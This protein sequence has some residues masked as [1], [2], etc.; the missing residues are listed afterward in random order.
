[1][2]LKSSMWHEVLTLLVSTRHLRGWSQEE[3]AHRV[4]YHS[5]TL[6]LWETGKTIPSALA[7]MLW[8]NALN[9]QLRL[10]TPQNKSTA[11]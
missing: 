4:G 5:N 3:L 1:M 7:F 11:D 10:G 9:L 2:L 6:R 8:T